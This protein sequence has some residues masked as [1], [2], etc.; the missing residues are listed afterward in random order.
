M[1]EKPETQPNDS[2]A[3]AVDVEVPTKQKPV[4]AAEQRLRDR[5]T[6]LY[7]LRDTLLAIKPCDLIEAAL[8]IEK[9]AKLDDQLDKIEKTRIAAR[10]RGNYTRSGQPSRR[11]KA[12][13]PASAPFSEQSVFSQ[14]IAA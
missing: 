4:S 8:Q 12:K 14:S 3:R 6:A 13:K 5:E 2:I 9:L 11:P 1:P 10:Q 7:T